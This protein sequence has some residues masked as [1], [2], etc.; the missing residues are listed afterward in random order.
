MQNENAEAK[1]YGYHLLTLVGCSQGGR[2]GLSYLVLYARANPPGTPPE[3]LSSL[4][5]VFGSLDPKLPVR[6]AVGPH[7]PS[8]VGA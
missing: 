1:G 5:V 3:L 7:S 4:L 2:Q 8:A 6:K